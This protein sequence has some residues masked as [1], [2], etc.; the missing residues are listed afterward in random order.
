MRPFSASIRNNIN[1]INFGKSALENI[2]KSF[3][4]FKIQ[5]DQELFSRLHH[6]LETENIKSKR[7]KE[8]KK[9]DIRYNTVY[10]LVQE[11]KKLSL[12]DTQ[13]KSYE[14]FKN[15]Q[16]LYQIQNQ[17]HLNKISKWQKDYRKKERREKI[18]REEELNKKIQ[19]EKGYPKDIIIQRLN[20]IK[21]KCES[22]IRKLRLKLT[23]KDN[24]LKIYK[25]QKEK[26][27]E[28]KKQ[29]LELIIQTRNQRIN[30]LNNEQNKQREKMRKKKKKKIREY[31]KFLNAKEM[32]NEQKRN[33]SDYY[34]NKYQIY[35]NHFDSILYKKDLDK[36]AL[37]QIDMISNDDPAL[38]GLT[39]NFK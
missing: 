26:H 39:N 2:R 15:H 35:T 31:N 19:T 3:D 5:K 12:M 32:I 22:K 28:E 7:N 29:N 1:Q 27:C 13:L 17:K 23:N 25:N 10:K 30:Q 37:N 8:Y 14:K 33:I 6:R 4:K 11:R 38:A 24:K 34:N 18:I 21:Q 20:E 9:R 36:V 16:N